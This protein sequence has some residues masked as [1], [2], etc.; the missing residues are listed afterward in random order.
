MPLACLDGLFV[1]VSMRSQYGT[2]KLHPDVLIAGQEG[3]DLA[4]AIPE[5]RSLIHSL[6]HI[7]KQYP[8]F[9]VLHLW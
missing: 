2:V 4:V 7:T 6:A 1:T 3:R 8:R 5:S 9:P